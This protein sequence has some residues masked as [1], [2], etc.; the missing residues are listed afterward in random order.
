[1]GA[2]FVSASLSSDPYLSAEPCAVFALPVLGYLTSSVS[3]HELVTQAL[4]NFRSTTLKRRKE[5]K[6]MED[7]LEE[8]LEEKQL[9]E[10]LEE[11]LEEDGWVDDGEEL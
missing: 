11:W 4:S 1:M 5:D 9:M 8:R 2:F 10:C 3:F 7:Y 6:P